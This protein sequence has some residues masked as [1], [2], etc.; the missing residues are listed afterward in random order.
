MEKKK[1]TFLKRGLKKSTLLWPKI[2]VMQLG[3]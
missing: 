2:Y 1:N 3:T